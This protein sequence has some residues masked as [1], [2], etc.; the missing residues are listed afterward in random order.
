MFVLHCVGSVCFG[1]RICDVGCVVLLNPCVIDEMVMFIALFT[2]I[3]TYNTN[4]QKVT[5]SSL[6][7]LKNWKPKYGMVDILFALRTCM[8]PASKLKQPA[9]NAEY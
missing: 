8:I 7:I 6:P 9:M 5:H 2:L 3:V 1:A 4:T